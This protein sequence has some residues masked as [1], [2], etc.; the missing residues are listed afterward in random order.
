MYIL[1]T[2][3]RLNQNQVSHLGNGVTTTEAFSK[4]L[5][6]AQLL[7]HVIL[8][9]IV[10]CVYCDQYFIVPDRYWIWEACYQYITQFYFT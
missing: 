4:K 5:I 10:L 1:V 8:Q 2:R 7:Q 9:R 3:L 6:V